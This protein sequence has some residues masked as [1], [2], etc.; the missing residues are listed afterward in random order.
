[1]FL[2]AF[3]AG[4]AAG[5]NMETLIILRALAGGLGCGPMTNSIGV[6]ADMFTA[7]ERG[8][9]GALFILAPFLGPSLSRRAAK[10][11]TAT[12]KAY[13]SRLERPDRIDDAVPALTRP[14]PSAREKFRGALQRPCVLL[15]MEPIVLLSSLYI[16][17]IYGTLY[18]LFDAFPI[19]FVR[20]RGWSVGI[21]GLAFLGVTVGL[22]CAVVIF[23]VFNRLHYGAV[24][25]R[26]AREGRAAPPEA[27][28]PPGILGSVL[29]P[30]GLFWFAWTSGPAVHWA[31]PVVGSG[32]FACGLILVFLSLLNYL[33][34]SYV[35]FTASVL[36]ANT[37][38]RSLFGCAFPLFTPYMYGTLGLE[39]AGSVPAFLALACAPFPYLFMIYGGR[40]R[41]RCKYARKAA[42]TLELMRAAEAETEAVSPAAESILVQGKAT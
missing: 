34:D 13:V 9:A 22:F 25:Q 38:L 41:M 5:D 17:I 18:M 15:S 40:L 16:A 24:V 33:I 14:Q 27:R 11:S 35:I 4:A 28:L 1:M 37:V 3:I 30:V 39:W 6:I 20:H 29:L 2:T 26:C 23:G 31:A 36:A 8:L 10:L 32:F 42:E 12:G 21:S 7:E 19:V